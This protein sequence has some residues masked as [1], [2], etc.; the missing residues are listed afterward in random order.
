MHA[1]RRLAGCGGKLTNGH[2]NLAAKC[3]AFLP[4]AC[5][6]V[7]RTLAQSFKAEPPD[8]AVK[9]GRKRISMFGDRS[10]VG[11]R[12]ILSTRGFEDLLGPISF[13]GILRMH[14]NQRAA[15]FDLAFISLGLVLGNS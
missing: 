11:G 15:P 7:A 8:H 14:R 4:A 1:G 10:L 3:A 6:N 13:G 12:D 2:R 5:F 9:S